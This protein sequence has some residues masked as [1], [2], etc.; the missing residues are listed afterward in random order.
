MMHP[1]LAAELGK[2]D[3]AE[4]VRQAEKA[5]RG[6]R[7]EDEMSLGERIALSLSQFLISSGERLQARYQPR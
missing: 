7:L 5:W 6:R 3:H 1:D 2:L 4:M